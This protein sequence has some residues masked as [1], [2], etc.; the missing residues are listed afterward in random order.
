VSL[1]PDLVE[2]TAAGDVPGLIG[3]LG[4][5]EDPD[6]PPKAVDALVAMGGAAVLEPLIGVLQDADADLLEKFPGAL[7]SLGD[8]RAIEPIAAL[9]RDHR[10]QVRDNAAEALRSLDPQL[11]A[12]FMTERG[13]SF[14]PLGKLPDTVPNLAAFGLVV[15]V[16]KGGTRGYLLTDDGLLYAGGMFSTPRSCSEHPSPMADLNAVSRGRYRADV[17]AERGLTPVTGGAGRTGAR[18]SGYQR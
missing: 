8:R 12:R 15:R 3:V 17:A 7:A 14:N 16:A 4:Y 18:Y 9:L 13:V 5:T 1:P 6:L 10:S 2:L 11:A